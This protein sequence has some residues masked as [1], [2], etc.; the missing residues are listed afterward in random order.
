M[1]VWQAESKEVSF[2]QR[3]KSECQNILQINLGIFLQ[4]GV[5]HHT[6]QNTYLHQKK[7]AMTE[8]AR[9]ILWRGKVTRLTGGSR[10]MRT[11][12]T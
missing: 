9:R 1:S 12:K 8:A 11:N 2:I 10:L 4:S 7:T 5:F 6:V 3:T